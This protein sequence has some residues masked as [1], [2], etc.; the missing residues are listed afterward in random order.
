M[1]KYVV[2]TAILITLLFSGCNA[3]KTQALRIC[4]DIPCFDEY[5]QNDIENSINDFLIRIQKMVDQKI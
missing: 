5:S 1:K 3:N 4:I 2:L